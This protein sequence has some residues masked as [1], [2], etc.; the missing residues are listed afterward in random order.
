[1]RAAL[2]A[3]V[4]TIDQHAEV[5][6]EALRDYAA[7]RGLEAVEFVDQG[8]SGAKAKRPALDEMLAAV[9]RREVDLVVCVKLDRL[10][11]SVRHLTEMAAEFDALGIDLVVLDQAIDTSTP[12]GRLLFHVLAAI[13]EFELDLIRERTKAGLAAARRRGKRL[14]RPPRLDARARRRVKRLRV[15]GN[16]IRQIASAVGCSPATIVRALA[17]S[18]G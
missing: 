18:Q 2:H 8:V 3:R 14:G 5:Q 7:R 12:T 11:R 1:M 6:L 17:G 15:A 16:S 10:A 4:S 13:G 9:H